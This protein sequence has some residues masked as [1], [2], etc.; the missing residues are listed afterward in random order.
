MNTYYDHLH[1][2]TNPKTDVYVT[3]TWSQTKKDWVV[4]KSNDRNLVNQRM[5]PSHLLGTGWVRSAKVNV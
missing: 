3:V 2:F 5:G 1:T 4:I